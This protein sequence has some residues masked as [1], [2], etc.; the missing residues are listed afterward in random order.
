GRA[1]LGRAAPGRGSPGQAAGAGGTPRAA[2]AAG[3]ADG[4]GLT[5]LVQVSVDGDP[6]RGGVPPGDVREVAEAIEAEPGLV[7]GG[8]MAVAPLGLTPAVAFAVLRDCSDTVRLVRPGATA[9][10]AGMSGDLEPAIA[11][12]STHIRIGTAL[13]GA[14]TPPVR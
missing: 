6:A 4:T 14:R 8:V 10:S 1:A 9:I 2:G 11:A 13:L 3:R 12:G 5:C 7:L